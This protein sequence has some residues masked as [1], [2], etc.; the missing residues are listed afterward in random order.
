MR[1]LCLAHEL[2]TLT[3]PGLEP[4]PLNPESSALTIWPMCLLTNV[5]ITIV[6]D[7]KR[8][9]LNDLLLKLNLTNFWNFVGFHQ[10][11][12]LH[13]PAYIHALMKKGHL[14]IY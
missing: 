1:V 10:S 7:S 3:L 5:I 12:K 14:S 6:K 4:R 9:L 13:L 2:N 11:V 8:I